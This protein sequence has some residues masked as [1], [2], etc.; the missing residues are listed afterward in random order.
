[1]LGKCITCKCVEP[2][3]N[4]DSDG[5]DTEVTWF[6]PKLNKNPKTVIEEEKI[7]CYENQF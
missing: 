1:M 6:C 4:Y 5:M 2:D 7:Q 3:F